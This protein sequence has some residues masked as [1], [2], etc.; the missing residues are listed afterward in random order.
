MFSCLAFRRFSDVHEFVKPNDKQAL[1]LM[2]ACAVA[3]VKEFPDIVFSYG[4]S[5]EYRYKIDFISECCDL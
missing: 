3:V 2:N 5:D 1:N 4:V